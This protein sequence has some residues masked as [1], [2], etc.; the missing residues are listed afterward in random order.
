MCAL[1]KPAHGTDAGAQ[2]QDMVFRTANVTTYPECNNG[3]WS[4]AS[5]AFRYIV[6]VATDDRGEPA[7]YLTHHTHDG[8]CPLARRVHAGPAQEGEP[9]MYGSTRSWFV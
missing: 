5:S 4:P 7:V 9:S 2:C 6:N 8:R 1:T 3:G